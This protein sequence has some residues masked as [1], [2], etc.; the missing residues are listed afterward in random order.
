MFLIAHELADL[1]V[2]GRQCSV[3]ENHQ[4]FVDGWT[5]ADARNG[6]DARDNGIILQSQVGDVEV[7]LGIDE[8]GLDLPD[9]HSIVV[10]TT[11]FSRKQKREC[12]TQ[13]AES[14]KRRSHHCCG[15]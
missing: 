6:G 9:L 2:S 15:Y 7:S 3:E 10:G 1:R 14:W 8:G 11:L 12:A 4:G 13:C 5:A